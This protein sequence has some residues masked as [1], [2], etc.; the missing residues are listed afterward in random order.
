[1]PDYPIPTREKRRVLL[2]I[3]PREKDTIPLLFLDDEEVTLFNRFANLSIKV[4][5][6]LKEMVVN[7]KLQL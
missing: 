5:I 3:F 1:L 4:K 2:I 6:K 7:Y